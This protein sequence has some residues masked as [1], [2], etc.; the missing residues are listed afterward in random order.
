[1]TEWK[2]PGRFCDRDGWE[3]FRETDHYFYRKLMPDGTLKRTKVS[4]GS[5][6]IGHDLWQR[7]LKQQLQVTQEYFNEK[8]Q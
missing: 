1:M 5:G 2:D 7:I 8:L 3:C 4:K 6:E